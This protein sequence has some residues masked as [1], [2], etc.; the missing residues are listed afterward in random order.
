M[1]IKEPSDEYL[2]KA[3]RL[4]AKESEKMLSR[5]TGKLPRRLEK[6]KLTELEALAIQ[7]ELEDEMLKEW[8]ERV[9]EIRARTEAE[10]SEKNK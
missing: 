2:A 7:L 3:A 5:M 4:S 10:A 1:K 8:R 6:E 9:A